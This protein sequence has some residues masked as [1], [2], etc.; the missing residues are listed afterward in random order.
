MDLSIFVDIVQVLFPNKY[1]RVGLQQDREVKANC[2]ALNPT[3][4]ETLVPLAFASK[5][6]QW[7]IP[8][9][10]PGHCYGQKTG[11]LPTNSGA[12]KTFRMEIL[13]IE[14]KKSVLGHPNGSTRQSSKVVRSFRWKD[15]FH[16]VFFVTNST[17][18][19]VRSPEAWATSSG[20]VQAADFP[21]FRM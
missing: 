20:P 12:F 7:V 21:H 9:W 4:L 2:Q 3:A 6:T 17:L 19:V 11:G 13:E 8:F 10:L 1:Y 18:S 14:L 5:V 15:S 16:D